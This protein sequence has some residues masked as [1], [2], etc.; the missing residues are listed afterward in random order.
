MRADSATQ[1]D[2]CHQKKI[3][4][5]GLAPKTTT[6]GLREHFSRHGIVADA[7]VLRWPDGRSRGFGYVTFADI[8]SANSALREGHRIGGQD[9]DVKRAVPGTNKLFVGGLPQNATAAEL[10]QHFE[11]FGVV[12]DAVVMMDP[13]TSRSRGFGFVCFPPGQDGADAVVAALEQYERHRLRG[14]WIEVKSAAP[15]HKLLVGASSAS[16]PMAAGAAVV[17]QLEENSQ[18]S[19][20]GSSSSVPRDRTGAPQ[21]QPRDPA[22]ALG[23]VTPPLGTS[24]LPLLSPPGLQQPQQSQPQYLITSS[25]ALCQEQAPLPSLL[26]GRRREQDPKSSNALRSRQ[27]KGGSLQT[28]KVTKEAENETFASAKDSQGNLW[29]DSTAS[30]PFEASHELRRGLEELLRLHQHQKL[31]DGHGTR[32]QLEERRGEQPDQELSLEE[33]SWGTK[34][35]A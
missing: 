23:V 18:Q 6:Q 25:E 11:W 10:R 33:H 32:T 9:V 34:V 4:V 8:T 21:Q 22:Q 35:E 30:S 13:T 2:Q 3:F 1:E 14:K 27:E 31:D 28:K 17:Q 19:G 12:S 20:N 29:S 16:T 7:V 26:A 5:G 15:P 24:P